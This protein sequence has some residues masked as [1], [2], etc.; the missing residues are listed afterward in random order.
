MC[1]CDV[2][3][4]TKRRA[5]VESDSLG[6]P[7][8][9]RSRESEPE[10]ERMEEREGERDGEKEHAIE[11]ERG[12]LKE[13]ERDVG[14]EEEREGVKEG[15]RRGDLAQPSCEGADEDSES[16]LSI[17]PSQSSQSEPSVI[18][19]SPTKNTEPTTTDN[20]GATLESD[21]MIGDD[22]VFIEELSA[23]ESEC[24]MA[25]STVECSDNTE[26]EEDT[27][28]TGSALVKS[29]PS[30][31]L[32]A[33]SPEIPLQSS[34]AES[35]LG[36]NFDQISVDRQRVRDSLSSEESDGDAEGMEIGGGERAG[37]CVAST[38]ES[39][40]SNLQ[41]DHPY[42][43]S[44]VTGESGSKMESEAICEESESVQMA[45][46]QLADHDYWNSNN[47][48]A[49]SLDQHQPP[50]QPELLS[51]SS[52]GDQQLELRSKLSSDVPDH[53]YCRQLATNS[54]GAHPVSAQEK[55]VTP[56]DVNAVLEDPAS[57][58][59]FSQ[60]RE[61][62]A[63][64]EPSRSKLPLTV[65]AECQT[66]P[67]NTA[68]VSTSTTKFFLDSSL[69]GG[70]IGRPLSTYVDTVLASEDVCVDDLWALH[71]QL[72]CSLFKISERLRAENV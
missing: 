12:Q 40:D 34:P 21:E 17:A 35:P 27:I 59:L 22:N 52:P 7:P 2:L 19:S 5:S 57:Q 9:K 49:P 54:T 68:E 46:A 18:L 70:S 44:L 55:L 13:G 24:E 8:K 45:P 62:I 60:T 33:G 66:E 16:Q 4:G 10:E 26:E 39:Q 47:S 29:C 61:V 41:H 31:P 23:D 14:R 42:F 67:P 38:A 6:P 72:M 36:G 56:G 48:T 58:E 32:V 30:P 53:T 3:Q 64:D 50:P 69:V 15:E 28:E 43:S 11:G 65:D 37:E 25:I 51:A 63:V 20:E 71:Q 1:C